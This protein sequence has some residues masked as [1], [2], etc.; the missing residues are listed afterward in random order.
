MR[1]SWLW[2]QNS[3]CA[4]QK[5][6]VI[7]MAISLSAAGIVDWKRMYSPIFCTRSATSGLRS[8]AL[9]GPRAPLRGPDTMAW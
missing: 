9:K 3:Y 2:A 6:P 7:R 8:S 1:A 4:P 5:R